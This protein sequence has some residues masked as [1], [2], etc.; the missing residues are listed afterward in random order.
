MCF[1]KKRKSRLLKIQ[2][3]LKTFIVIF[4][5]LGIYLVR[6]RRIPLNGTS[7]KLLILWI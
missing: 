5:F 7:F 1:E 6:R 3:Q 4:D 2:A